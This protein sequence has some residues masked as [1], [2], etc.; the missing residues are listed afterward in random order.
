L[1]RWLAYS[2]SPLLLEEL[3]YKPQHSLIDQ[4]LHATLGPHTTNGDG[5]GVG[6][7]AEGEAP[8][9]YKGTDPAWNDRNLRELSQHIRSGLIFAHVRAST[10][11]P[12]QQSN[13]HPF[14]HGKWLWMHN[15]Q[16]AEFPKLKRELVMAVDPSLYPHIEGSA[17]SEVFFFLALTFGLEENP[18]RAVERAVAFIEKIAREFGVPHPMR[19]SVA[20]SNGET[21]WAFRYASIGTPPSLFFST[22]VGTLR[23]QFPEVPAF[24]AL[25]DEARLIV[26][27]PLG[28]RVG[29]WNEVP[30][31][32]CGVVRTGEDELRP[33]CPTAAA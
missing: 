6:W 16:I 11:T 25:S 4:S 28:E 23:E 5:F 14:R 21:V 15:G 30:E 20:V 3:L 10:G 9:L 26:S 33:F 31:S 13:C 24:Q 1:C 8:A 32:T 7:Y 2:G 17:D 22:R 18:S 27:E 29:A 12:I 19:M